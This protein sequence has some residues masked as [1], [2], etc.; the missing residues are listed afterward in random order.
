MKNPF[1]FLNKKQIEAPQTDLQDIL[2]HIV[3]HGE[4]SLVNF[5][6]LAGFRAR[7]SQLRE[8]GVRF[9]DIPITSKNRHGHNKVIMLHKCQNRT[10]AESLYKELTDEKSKHKAG[11]KE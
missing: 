4:V 10:F 5:P 1:N 2:L 3:T 7:I 9:T 6:M 11:P 8:K